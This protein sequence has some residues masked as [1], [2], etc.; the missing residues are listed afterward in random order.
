MTPADLALLEAMIDKY[1][2]DQV[3]TSLSGIC[4]LKAVQVASWNDTQQ[5]RL[6]AEI[7]AAVNVIVTKATRL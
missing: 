3:L 5:A 1:G 7:G 6:W 2:L 4:D